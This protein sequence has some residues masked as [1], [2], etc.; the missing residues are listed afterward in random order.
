MRIPLDGLA[1]VPAAP[2]RAPREVGAETGARWRTRLLLADGTRV[3]LPAA[4]DLPPPACA[5]AA[6]ELVVDL[7]GLPVADAVERTAEGACASGDVRSG[8]H[9]FGDVRSGGSGS[10]DRRSEGFGF[11]GGRSGLSAP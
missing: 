11:G 7:G 10:G 6:G 2:H 3:R 4:P 5:D 9:R 8:G 1:A